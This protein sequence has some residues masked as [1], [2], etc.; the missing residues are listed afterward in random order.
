M[1]MCTGVLAESE[2]GNGDVLIVT[3]FWESVGEIVH[4]CPA[5]Q[6]WPPIV[7]D[8]AELFMIVIEAFANVIIML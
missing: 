4:V 6:D 1:A 7:T 8:D 5:A 3:E 2:R